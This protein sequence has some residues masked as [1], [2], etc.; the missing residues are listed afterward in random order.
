M[1][2]SEKVLDGHILEPRLARN[3]DKID[4]LGVVQFDAAFKKSVVCFLGFFVVASKFRRE[5]TC[6]IEADYF[7]ADGIGAKAIIVL[8]ARVCI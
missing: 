4:F 3:Y 7:S 8:T 5:F 6:L 1:L 2:G